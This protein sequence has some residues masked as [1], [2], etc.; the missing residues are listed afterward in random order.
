VRR[1]ACSVDKSVS[2][3]LPD[4]A[5]R[6]ATTASAALLWAVAVLVCVARPAAAS[7]SGDVKELHNSDLARYYY[8]YFGNMTYSAADRDDLTF[9]ENPRAT[10]LLHV[11]CSHADA[12][13]CPSGGG[14]EVT[15]TP[16]SRHENEHPHEVTLTGKIVRP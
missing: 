15:Y 13:F 3:S 8:W 1:G 6:R 4:V 2:M 12:L 10:S 9:R 7:C 16:V 5:S 11:A 14:V